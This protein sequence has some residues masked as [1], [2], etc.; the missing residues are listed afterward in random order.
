MSAVE[1]PILSARDPRF[2]KTLYAHVGQASAHTLKYYLDHDGY[3]A[4]RKALGMTPEAV[5]EE[6]KHSGL[7]GRGGAGF[8]T[9]LKWSF[10]PKDDGKQHYIVCNADESEP[11][12]FKDRYFMEDDPHQ[13][14][15]GMIIAGRAIRAT[16]G[17]I[18]VRGEYRKAYDR[19]IAAIDE[20]RAAGYLGDSV[21]DTGTAFDIHVHRGA[22]AYIC[23]E[24]TAL[25]N[26]LE[27]LRG[28]PRTKPPFPAQAGIYGKPTTVNN[29]ESLCSVV[30]ILSK[31][32]GW[33]TAMGTEKSKGVKVF[34]VSGAAKRPGVY[35]LP[36]GASF[37]ELIYDFAGGPS[38]PIKA[39]IPGGSSTPPLPWSEALLDTPM[40]YES[41]VGLGSA[42]GTGGV[43][44]VPESVSMVDV[45]WNITR[46][47]A[48]ES[49]GK[50][51]PCRE[52]VSGWMVRLME[53]IAKGRGEPGDVDL[54]WNLLD[55]IEGRAFCPLAD[56]AVWPVRGSLKHF[57]HEYEAQIREGRPVSRPN[58]WR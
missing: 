8:M 32:A 51:T 30:H 39:V 18:Y 37:R 43:I 53:K 49:C 25:L 28:I 42:L 17:Y 27:G 31:G 40:S 26:S 15:E 12:S 48:H 36:M 22:G 52:G 2:T 5:V 19:L 35:E 24:E 6:V 23:G 50:C 45:M 54:L 13:L 47:Y 21:M 14:I 33:F 34:Q 46:F 56:A 58:R 9:G 11:G 7:R 29:V 57:R 4:A 44:L 38:E 55:N 3:Q 41:L 20:A 10:M 1:G 16:E